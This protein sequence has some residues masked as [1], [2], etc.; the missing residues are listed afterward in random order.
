MTLTP[1]DYS[2]AFELVLVGQPTQSQ[3]TMKAD[4]PPLFVSPKLSASSFAMPPRPMKRTRSRS[5]DGQVDR[6]LVSIST[7]EGMPQLDSPYPTETGIA[8]PCE[9][10]R[11][12][13]PQTGLSHYPPSHGFLAAEIGNCPHRWLLDDSAVETAASGQYHRSTI[14][15]SRESSR[16]WRCGEFCALQLCSLVIDHLQGHGL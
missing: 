6:P 2:C 3:S 14:P 11:R 10:H 15:T 8:C 12:P 16:R 5:R 9:R 4:H 7:L 1:T 13:P